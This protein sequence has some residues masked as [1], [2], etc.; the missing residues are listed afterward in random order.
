MVSKDAKGGERDVLRQRN[1]GE[2]REGDTNTVL[3]S[4]LRDFGYF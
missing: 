4:G 1:R 2:S 3:G